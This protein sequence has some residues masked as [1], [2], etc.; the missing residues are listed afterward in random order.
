MIEH[1]LSMSVHQQ[2]LFAVDSSQSGNSIRFEDFIAIEE[3][4]ETKDLQL[5]YSFIQTPFGEI[6]V[7]STEKSICLIWF[8]DD[9]N[10]TITELS[11]RFPG[12][13]IENKEED[14]HKDILHYFHPDN[15]KWPKIN[16]QVQGSPFQLKVWKVLLQIPFGQVTNYK[17]IADQIEQPNASRAVGTAIGKNPIAYLIPCHRVVQTNGQLGGY[18]WGIKRKSAIIQWEQEAI[19]R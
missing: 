6:L 8:T 4:I 13:S 17:N 15:N 3:F 9:R 10:E 11:K 19:R 1:H 5:H 7:A 18:M 14:L 16:L 2:D 12:A